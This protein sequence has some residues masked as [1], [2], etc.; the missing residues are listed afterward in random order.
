MAAKV[1]PALVLAGQPA[2]DELDLVTVRPHTAA[3]P[4]CFVADCAT[5]VFCFASAALISSQEG[6]RQK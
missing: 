5:S 4:Y 6:A 2:D 1:R 3:V